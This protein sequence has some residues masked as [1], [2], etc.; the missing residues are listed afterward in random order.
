MR[1]SQMRES[2]RS[3]ADQALDRG[4]ALLE[5]GR[6]AFRTRVSSEDTGPLTATAGEIAQIH[7]GNNPATYEA[8]S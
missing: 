7:S 5:E 1:G 4:M 3:R 6:R 2:L 8:R